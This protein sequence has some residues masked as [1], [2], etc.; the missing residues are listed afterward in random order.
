MSLI[1]IGSTYFFKSYPDF[2]PHDVD[3]IDIIDTNDFAEKRTIRGQG[4]DYILLRNKPKQQL[5]ADARK[6]KLPMVVGKFLIPEFNNKI[7]FTIEDLPQLQ[8]L[9]DRLDEKHLYE[10]IIYEAYLVNGSFTLT[11]AQRDA[12]YESYRETRSK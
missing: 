12:A 3:Y 8:P 1:L 11:N 2:K 6:S 7:G 10:K 9:V 5:I 4:K